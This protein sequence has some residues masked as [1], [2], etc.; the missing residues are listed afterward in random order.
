MF[1]ELYRERTCALNAQ[2][3][4]LPFCWSS[5]KDS[6]LAN[7]TRSQ[8]TRQPAEIS[9]KVHF[10][11]RRAGWRVNLKGR[12]KIH[13]TVHVFA[14]QYTLLSLAWVTGVFQIEETQSA[15][16]CSFDHTATGNLKY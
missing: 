6:L 1:E 14:S 2:C 5:V 11:E 12:K 7:S 3:V 4:C 9:T 16:E 13:G 8:R 15:G 10:P